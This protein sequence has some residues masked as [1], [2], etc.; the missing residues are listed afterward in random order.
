MTRTNASCTRSSASAVVAGEQV[1][2]AQRS[3][4]VLLVQPRQ[5]TPTDHAHKTPSTSP[6]LRSR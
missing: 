5:V 6:M 1:R 3:R 2:Q 4:S